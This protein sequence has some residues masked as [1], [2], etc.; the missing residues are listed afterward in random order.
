[1]SRTFQNIRLFENLNVVDNV[2]VVYGHKLKY[3]MFD[4]L[5]FSPS[6]AGGRR[7]RSTN[8]P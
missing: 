1:M 6:R 4:E 5:F 8:E 3:R 7:R 2:K